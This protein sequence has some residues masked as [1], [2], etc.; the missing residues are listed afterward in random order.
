MSQTSFSHMTLQPYAIHKNCLNI[1]SSILP[2]NIFPYPT[3]QYQP[4]DNIPRINLKN[5]NSS[6]VIC[7]HLRDQHSQDDLWEVDEMFHPLCNFNHSQLACI[8]Y[9]FP[10]KEFF[11]WC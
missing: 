7:W 8:C 2:A 11:Y 10:T 6:C 9:I 5:T 3:N 4:K 1:G